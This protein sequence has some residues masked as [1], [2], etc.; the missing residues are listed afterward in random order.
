MLAGTKFS[1]QYVIHEVISPHLSRSSSRT[2][3]YKAAGWRGISDIPQSCLRIPT[4]TRLVPRPPA[5]RSLRQPARQREPA[6][7]PRSSAFLPSSPS[8]RPLIL[9]HKSGE[10]SRPF[11]AP[12]SN[13]AEICWTQLTPRPVTEPLTP[14]TCTHRACPRAPRTPLSTASAAQNGR[15]ACSAWSSPRLLEVSDPASYSKCVVN[16]LP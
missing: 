12:A 5:R 15:R 7:A 4:P 3:S 16:E 1:A 2:N 10:P 11:T 9:H 6:S 13:F 8:S 14:D